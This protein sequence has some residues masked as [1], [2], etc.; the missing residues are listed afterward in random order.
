[1]K[2]EDIAHVKK[3]EDLVIFDKASGY[4]CHHDESRQV[5]YH[6]FLFVVENFLSTDEFD[7]IVSH[8]WTNLVMK[9]EKPQGK[10]Y[11][12]SSSM[13]AENGFAGLKNLGATCYMNSMIQQFYNVPI[14]RYSMM[15]ADDGAAPAIVQHQGREI[16][17]N[18]LHQTQRLF[19]TLELTDRIAYNT[20][21]YCF[22][23][24]DGNEPVNVR[25]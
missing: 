9:M 13:R 8:Y 11:D 5:A 15:N 16:D 25:V 19:T 21:D 12:P 10:K 4:K 22:S 7:G 2:E 18:F 1:M 3:E 17:D 23:Y 14:F 6:L 24:K 20:R